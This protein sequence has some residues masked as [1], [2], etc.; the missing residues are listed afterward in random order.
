MTYKRLISQFSQA[1]LNLR[2]TFLTFYK[3]RLFIGVNSIRLHFTLA[4]TWTE[5]SVPIR[6]CHITTKWLLITF[7]CQRV[8][9]VFWRTSHLGALWTSALTRTRQH[10]EKIKRNENQ[11]LI[12]NVVAG[13]KGLLGWFWRL[14]IT[15]HNYPLSHS[16]S[17]GAPHFRVPSDTLPVVNKTETDCQRWMHIPTRQV[18]R[19]HQI[20]PGCQS[21]PCWRLSAPK[22]PR[23]L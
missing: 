9:S 10:L 4:Y 5:R 21:S 18:C 16:H 6:S 23:A 20:K 1:K 15:H 3:P 14:S 13:N 22:L 8:C 11:H 7:L 2:D 17:R 19:S 12:S